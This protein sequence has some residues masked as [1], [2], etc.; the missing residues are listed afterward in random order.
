VNGE[1]GYHLRDQDG[2]G[3]PD[4][5][6]SFSVE[7]MRHA[8]WD[9]VMGGGYL[10]TGFGTTY[11]AGHRDP[12]PFDPDAARNADWEQQIGHL[13]RFFTALDW[14][15]LTPADELITAKEERTRDRE[16]GREVRP[17]VRT[18]WALANPGQT[19]VLYVRG[20]K[21]PVELDLGARARTYR[22]RQYDPRTGASKDLGESLVAGAYRYQAP[23]DQDW[24]V[25]LE[26][27]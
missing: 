13:N 11:F 24:V 18:W 27:R 3:K 9:I 20:T 12:G 8:S 19:Y 23:D 26:G 7:D 5:S 10:V 2:D 14:R 6:N 4:K 17:P 21:E 22:A 1:Y 25:L 15:K 16:V